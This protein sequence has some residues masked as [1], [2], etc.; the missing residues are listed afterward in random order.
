MPVRE[1]RR[2]GCLSCPAAAEIRGIRFSAGRA[3]PRRL[4][5]RDHGHGHGHGD[6]DGHG[7]D[8]HGRA[9]DRAGDP[10]HEHGRDRSP[11]RDDAGAAAAVDR[12]DLR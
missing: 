1:M 12:A 10:A 7:H 4:G 11:D 6:D 8:D 9:H 3:P 5:G 2:A